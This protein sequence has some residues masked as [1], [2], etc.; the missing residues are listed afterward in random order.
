[1][2]G[3][4]REKGGEERGGEGSEKVKCSSMIKLFTCNNLEFKRS[5]VNG[6]V[7]R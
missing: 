7:C 2:R 5:F 3:K 4:G 1:M 6:D